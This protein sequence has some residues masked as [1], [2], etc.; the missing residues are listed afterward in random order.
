M[1]DLLELSIQY[2]SSAALCKAKTREI[3]ALMDLGGLDNEREITL[4][5]EVTLLTAMT[6]ECVATAN[7]LKNYFERRQRLDRIRK[8]EAGE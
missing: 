6:R 8:Q 3:K 7:Y 1:T 4:R 5:R 2:R